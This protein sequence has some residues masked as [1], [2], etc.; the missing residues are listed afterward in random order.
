MKDAITSSDVYLKAQLLCHGCAVHEKVVFPKNIN[1]KRILL[2]AH[3]TE[4]SHKLLPDDIIIGGP[5]SSCIARIRYNPQSYLKIIQKE[6]DF[7][8]KNEKYDTEHRISFVPALVSS[9][10]FIGDNKLESICSYLGCDL[11]GLIP[12]NYCFYFNDGK[13]CKFCEILD[14]FKNQLDYRKA[15]KDLNTIEK[16]VVKALNSNNHIKYLAVTTGNL[17]SYDFT[18][19][20]YSQIGETLSR[21]SSFQN[22]QQILATLMPP[23]DW[24]LISKIKEAGFNKIYFALEVFDKYHF[25]RIC[26]GKKEY[27]YERMLDALEFSTE[28]FGVGNVYTNFVYGIQSLDENLNPLSYNPLLENDKSVEACEKM[29]QKKIIPAFTLYH[30]SG[31]NGIGQIQL[32]SGSVFNFFE[33]WGELV[34]RSGLVKDDQ[35][36]LFGPKTLSNTLFNDGF[37]L[38]KLKLKTDALKANV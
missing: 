11:L 28:I 16:A 2:Y 38:A 35:T 14:T 12:S 20:Y 25:E 22:L 36:V 31:Y 15:F 3:S 18:A 10:D 7:Y 1:N 29:I 5:E 23:D 6:N 34:L 19:N 37:S 26:P 30:Y 8:V 33:K 27:G 4:N 13:Q 24:K 32:D 9:A 17:K 21:H